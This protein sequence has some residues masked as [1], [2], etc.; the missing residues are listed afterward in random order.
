MF[1]VFSRVLSRFSHET[2]GCKNKA[3][4]FEDVVLYFED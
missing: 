4:Q 2:E 3:F 1:K